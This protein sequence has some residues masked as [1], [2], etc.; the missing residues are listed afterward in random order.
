MSAADTERDQ[1]RA[2]F[3]HRL[4]LERKRLGLTQQQ[5]ADI[6]GVTRVTQSKFERGR[7]RP[8]LLYLIRISFAGADPYFILLNTPSFRPRELQQIFIEVDYVA[9]DDHGRLA[10]LST[11]TDLFTATCEHVKTTRHDPRMRKKPFRQ[12]VQQYLAAARPTTHS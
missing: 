6:A 1:A 10:D 8:D 4:R 3:G 2:A 12:I 5:L 11:R 9:R 7:G